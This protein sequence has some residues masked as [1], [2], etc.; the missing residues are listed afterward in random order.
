M[1]KLKQITNILTSKP[2]INNLIYYYIMYNY[3]I[4]GGLSYKL[5]K[6]VF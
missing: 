3:P 6:I 1:T 5:Y 2:V 4:I